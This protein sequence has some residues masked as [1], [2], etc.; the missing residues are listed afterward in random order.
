ME[1]NT[2]YWVDDTIG[3]N[4]SLEKVS[5]SDINESQDIQFKL[6]FANFSASA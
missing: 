3:T 4:S 6:T 1:K 5:P 2:D